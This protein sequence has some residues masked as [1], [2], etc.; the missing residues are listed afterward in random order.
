MYFDDRDS[1]V[2]I[3]IRLW[4]GQPRNCYLILGSSEAHSASCFVGMSGS[5]VAVKQPGQEADYSPDVP[6]VHPHHHGVHRDTFT[7]LHTFTW[8]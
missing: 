3:V 6:A 5:S 7:L 1:V 8:C 2:S 4:A